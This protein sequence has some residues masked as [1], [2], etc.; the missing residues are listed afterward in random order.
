[1]TSLK[2]TS[3]LLVITGGIAAY[4]SLELIRGLR[5]SGASVRAILTKGGEQFVTPLSVSSL[6]EH[7]V[8]TDLWS[9]KDES[10]MGH[11]R[12][13]READLIIVA[14]ASADFMAKMAH[15]MAN[16]LASTT[17]LATDTDTTPI[18]LAPAMN[19]KMWDNAAT[20]RNVTTL[21][22]QSVHM[23]GPET[24]DMA[25]GEHGMG[26]M[27][28]PDDILAAIEV[29][30]SKKKA[31]NDKP[32]AGKTAIVTS[33][34][35][36][37][38]IDPVRFIG[39]RSSGKQGHAI[40][41]ALRYAG[42][43]VTYITGP[44]ALPAPSG[45]R[46]ISIETAQEMLEACQNSLPADIAVCAA[47]VSD[48]RSDAQQSHKMKKRDTQSPPSLSLTENQDILHIIAT[49]KTQRPALVV[50][51]AAE[52]QNLLENAAAKL[53][54]KGCDWIIANDVSE[55]AGEKVFGADKNH[56]Y[57]VT[58]KTGNTEETNHDEWPRASKT[59]IA[60][61]LVQ[62]ITKHF[63][64]DTHNHADDIAAE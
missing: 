64:K 54:S 52:T 25:C 6:C 15:G 47:A 32:L 17:L 57:L 61:Q 13:T 48:W 59:Q 24:G 45:V 20:Q 39:N 22:A 41:C 11:I 28:E 18:M 60:A 19:H 46:T 1:M 44:T 30:L 37:E 31:L 12:L 35:T 42:V 53:T 62:N 2:N 63:Q 26:R 50:G 8:Y 9:L 51:F 33:G 38:P 29:R 55:A 4:K 14:P 56:V 49:H 5:K 43:D 58:S 16:D 27:S 3:I 7:E 23:I 34:P 10:E 36:F 40:A 21:T